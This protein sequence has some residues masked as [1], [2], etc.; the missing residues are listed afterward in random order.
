MSENVK[1]AL[2]PCRCKMEVPADFIFYPL[3]TVIRLVSFSLTIFRNSAILATNR[4]GV[5][6]AIAGADTIPVLGDTTPE[7]TSSPLGDFSFV[8]LARLLHIPK[9]GNSALIRFF[10]PIDYDKLGLCC[11]PL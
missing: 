2:I 4:G 8:Y 10:P 6:E 7:G 5:C 1:Y 3:K 11:H 9:A